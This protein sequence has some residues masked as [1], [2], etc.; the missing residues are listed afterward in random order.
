MYSSSSLLGS[1]VLH[2]LINLTPG[3]NGDEQPL[4]TFH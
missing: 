3:C 2:K 1:V 4:A